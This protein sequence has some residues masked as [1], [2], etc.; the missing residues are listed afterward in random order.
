MYSDPGCL[1]QLST[2]LTLSNGNAIGYA[3]AVSPGVAGLT[4]TAVGLSTQ[5]AVEFVAPYTATAVVSVQADP[6]V[7]GVNT[8][9]STAQQSTLRA[10]VLDGT[11]ANNLVKNAQVAFT[12]VNDPSGGYLSQPSVV[13]TGADGTASVSYIAGTSDTKLDGV[14]I[15]AQLQGASNAVGNVKLTVAKR[16]LFIT[17]GTG[18][19]LATPNS[20]T[21][22][23]DYAVFVTD[24][25]GNPV[26][27]VNLTSS[28]RP[29]NYYK[30]QLY[31]V[32]VA[33]PW[34]VGSAVNG[35][36]APVG[37]ANEDVNSDGLLQPG[38]D[39]N[40]D[41]VLTPGNAITVTPTAV[42]DAKGQATVSLNYARDHAN[43]LDF[44]LTIRGQVSGSE[45]RYVAYSV[46]PGLAADFSALGTAPPG[47]I[48]PY[49]I[50]GTCTN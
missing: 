7:L 50:T 48:S 42:T 8:A 10:I 23:L 22:Q 47:K 21:Y 30:G 40:G 43:W 37:C 16:A 3:Q 19:T 26:S 6:A 14:M 17:A 28:V 36:P 29:R 18:N 1:A 41:G 32:G 27:G 12:V 38:E 31:F 44:D 9:G 15:Q 20:S 13:T 25:A 4:A 11:P 5:G 45:A 39:I 34:Q 33:G 49:G 24:A 2:P 46:L 35:F